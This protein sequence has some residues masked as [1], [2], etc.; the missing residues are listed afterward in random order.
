MGSRTHAVTYIVQSD[1]VN[2][3]PYHY[4][5]LSAPASLLMLV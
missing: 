1:R 4:I 5:L 3:M 2:C